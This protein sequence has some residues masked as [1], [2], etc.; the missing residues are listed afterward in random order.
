MGVDRSGGRSHA[1]GRSGLR[2]EAVGQRRPRHDAAVGDP[3]GT[4]ETHQG[5]AGSAR[6]RGSAPDPADAAAGRS[7]ADGRVRARGLLAA[8]VRRGRRLFRR[9]PVLIAPARPVDRRR[10]RQGH[11][12]G[13][14]DVQPAGRGQGL[15]DR[16]RAACGTLRAGQ[17]HSLRPY[18]R[19][20]LHQLLLLR[21]RLRG[22]V[23]DVCERRTLS[24]RPDQGG[25][26]A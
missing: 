19:G 14:V 21:R 9:D 2:A 13:A 16:G 15:R 11:S 26:H 18:F 6:A 12:G 25:R 5:G 23:P 1:A 7:A 4:R 22:R 17:H 10:R 3:G 8:G 24:A 20:A